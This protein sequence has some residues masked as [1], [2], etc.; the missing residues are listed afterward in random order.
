MRKKASPEKQGKIR[1]LKALA[2]CAALTAADAF[3]TAAGMRLEMIDEA[4]PLLAGWMSVSP[5]YTGLA[6]FLGTAALLAL[7]Y[8][9]SGR[10]SWT[11]GAVS[12]IAAVK[13][14]VLGLHFSW[15]LH[16]I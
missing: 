3:C 7:L 13:L 1:M 16:L 14:T 11:G 10:V 12:G 4:N 15:I 8:A 2:V 6:V 9:V 5:E